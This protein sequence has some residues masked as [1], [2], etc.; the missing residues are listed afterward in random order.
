MSESGLRVILL[1]APDCHLCDHARTVLH[2]LTQ[3]STSFDIE[4]I[5]WSDPAG[6]ALV[7]RDGILFPPALYVNDELWGYGR[8]SERALRKRFAACGVAVAE[9]T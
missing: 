6:A 5:N 9:M 2:H 8:L 1:S 4:E 3:N 7:R